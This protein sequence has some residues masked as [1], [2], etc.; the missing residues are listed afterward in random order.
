MGGS[1]TPSFWDGVEVPILLQPYF[2]EI[3]VYY[4]DTKSPSLTAFGVD[5]FKFEDVTAV[6]ANNWDFGVSSCDDTETGCHVGIL[7]PYIS[8]GAI[9][10]KTD[11]CGK[12]STLSVGT[13]N[14]GY[15]NAC[16]SVRDE[17]GTFNIIC[18]T[19]SGL[20]FNSLEDPFALKQQNANTSYLEYM[21]KYDVKDGFG[22]GIVFGNE[23][24]EVSKLLNIVFGDEFTNTINEK[25]LNF[26][27]NIK[28]LDKADTLAIDD[29]GENLGVP[30]SGLSEGVPVEIQ[31]L[32]K[33]ASIKYEDLFGVENVGGVYNPKNV[34]VLLELGEN[35]SAGEILFTKKQVEPDSEYQSY[36][37]RSKNV[38]EQLTEGFLSGDDVYP[39][40]ALEDGDFNTTEY[41]FWRNVFEGG[42]IV[43]EII[44]LSTI[45]EIPTKAEWEAI[46]NKRIQY[47]LVV[48]LLG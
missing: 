28:S 6:S 19:A 12:L 34:G 14:D 13:S 24:S 33:L 39:L 4:T 25:I 30:T 41:Y 2:E 11:D 48:N 44:D 9:V 8:G 37:V 5:S 17:L 38:S 22:R 27:S 26:G 31:T 35:I 47:F 23:E 45:E 36:I 21:C 32:L 1:L 16:M 3:P 7:T 40:S 46:I 18:T 10:D 42:E 20:N 29:L 15:I 43:N